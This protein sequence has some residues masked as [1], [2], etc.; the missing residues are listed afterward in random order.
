MRWKTKIDLSPCN[1][2]SSELNKSY[3][4]SNLKYVSSREN[5]TEYLVKNKI[6][7]GTNGVSLSAIMSN[8]RE[9]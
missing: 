1:K 8:P 7:G 9:A 3:S 2:G 6:N 5:L 4:K